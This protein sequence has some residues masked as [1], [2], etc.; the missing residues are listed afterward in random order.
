[1]SLSIVPR[2]GLAEGRLR[3]PVSSSSARSLPNSR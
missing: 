2:S 1:M 3:A